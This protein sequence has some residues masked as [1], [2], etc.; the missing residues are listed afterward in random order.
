MDATDESPLFYLKSDTLG[1]NATGIYHPNTGEF[2]VLKGSQIRQDEMPGLSRDGKR[3]SLPQERKKL[4]D[5]FPNGIL[6]RDFR[7]KKPS[8]AA[9]IVAGRSI[10]GLDA[11]KDQAGKTLKEIFPR[12]AQAYAEAEEAT[13]IPETIPY[14][15]LL[16]VK[17]S[18]WQAPIEQGN[19]QYGSNVEQQLQKLRNI[20]PDDL[21]VLHWTKNSTLTH[22]DQTFPNVS[23][24][25][26][27][28]LGSVT[29]SANAQNN[30]EVDW[31]K[32]YDTP[33]EWYF[34]SLPG[35]L[36]WKIDY[37]H[38][39]EKA[40]HPKLIDFIF[41][42]T[43]QDID[44]FRNQ[45]FWQS[46]YGDSLETEEESPAVE[47]I[48]LFLPEEEFAMFVRRLQEKKSIILKG[49]PGTGKTL[50]TK[51]L[52]HA[53]SPDVQCETVQF[54]Q[55]FSYE[56]FVQGLRVNEEQKLALRR[57]K[58]L[59]FID[60]ANKLPEIPHVLI[61]DEINRG[62]PSSIFGEMLSI[63]EHTKRSLQHAITLAYSTE[64]TYLPAN[65]YL[66]GTMNLA[67]H[68]IAPLDF[69]FRRR[70]AFLELKPLFNETWQAYLKEK[71]K[72]EE[73]ALI[74]EIQTRLENLNLAIAED[75]DLGKNFLIGHSFFT[76]NNPIDSLHQWFNDIVESELKPLLE[77]YWPHNI[78]KATE[79]TNKLSI[80]VDVD[81]PTP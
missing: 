7:Y 11:W 46:R 51:H 72:P 81:S 33:R 2:T 71:S 60:R 80:S 76:P 1:Y 9:Q 4:F 36:I 32:I 31:F 68:S 61:I 39:K 54:H 3:V 28:A 66:I 17:E 78:A 44:W 42:D 50:I 58:M 43:P 57:G 5:E 77:E 79:Q 35:A 45:P 47:Q 75:T 56:D 64:P 53:L 67:D 18:Q 65:L 25:Y 10:S 19:W 52:A 30:I 73:H 40:Y 59:T 8:T 24:I 48:T 49:P 69:A 41:H 55:N 27:K 21:V 29:Q 16:A 74:N 38:H 6:L 70:F 62:N 15:W 26:I 14:C 23:T 13:R 37:N 63:I 12:E 22:N 34:Y 20:Q